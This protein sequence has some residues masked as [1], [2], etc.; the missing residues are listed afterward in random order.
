MSEASQWQ[1]TGGLFEPPVTPVT[2]P[3]WLA[4]PSTKLRSG[5]CP[6]GGRAGQRCF[7]LAVSQR[8]NLVSHNTV[9]SARHRHRPLAAVAS[10]STQFPWS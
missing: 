6:R 3:S 8:M 10:S 4:V 5:P 2:H 9:D 7:L 1:A